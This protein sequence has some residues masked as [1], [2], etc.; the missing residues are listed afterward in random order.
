MTFTTKEGKEAWALHQSIIDNEVSR[1][2]L[3]ATNISLL[4]ELK[5]KQL[6]RAI[7][8]D[9]T[10]EFH[11]YL[12]QLEVFYSRN[13][14]RNYLVI[15]DKFINGLKMTWKHIDDIPISRLF[16]IVSIVD[17]DNVDDWLTKA[18]TLT[19]QDWKNELNEVRGKPT[20]DKCYHPKEKLVDYQI[21][22][23]CGFKYRGIHKELKK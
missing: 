19:T 5:D 15:N 2:Q 14:I 9:E 23:E 22:S 3:F 10:A 7:L 11:A 4:A 17:D 13:Q 6:Y 18:R 16:D 20:T 21:C 1:R 8:G 12:G